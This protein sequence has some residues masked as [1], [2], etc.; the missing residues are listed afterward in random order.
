M[1]F[2]NEDVKRFTELKVGDAIPQKGIVPNWSSDKRV[3]VSF[4]GANAYERSSVLLE[5][6]FASC[7]F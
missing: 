6:I 3:G 2:T 4:M 7:I 1:I 5:C